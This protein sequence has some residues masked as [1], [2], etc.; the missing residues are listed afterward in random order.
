MP[1][2]EHLDNEPAPYLFFL[3]PRRFGK[4]LF[5]SMLISYYGLEH[6]ERFDALFGNFYIGTHPT[7]RANSYAVLEFE[8]S[9][10]DTN[11]PE[12]AQQGFHAN[13]L[14]GIENFEKRYQQT[15]MDYSAFDNPATDRKPESLRD[16]LCRKRGKSS[17]SHGIVSRLPLVRLLD[18]RPIS[19]QTGLAHVREPGI[20]APGRNGPGGKQRV[21]GW[22]RAE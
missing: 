14:L 3:R 6:Q 13:V 9:R 22:N 21:L 1:H 4:S 12:H 11:S 2:I 18:R 15:F 8:F 10:I 17:G 7:P 5:N 19:A 16:C 20:P